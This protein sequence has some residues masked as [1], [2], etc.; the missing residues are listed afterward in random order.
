MDSSFEYSFSEKGG[1]FRIE[2]TVLQ[3]LKKK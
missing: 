3:Q 1:F 2:F